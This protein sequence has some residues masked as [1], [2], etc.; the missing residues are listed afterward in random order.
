[1]V[2]DNNPAAPQPPQAAGPGSSGV[3]VTVPPLPAGINTLRVVQQV[4]VGAP[5]PKNVVESN[6]SLFYLQPVIQQPPTPGTPAGGVT[7]VTVQLEPA[8][9]STQRVQLL[10]N[11]LAP[12]AAP[13]P[14][15]HLRRRSVADRREQRDLRYLRHPA[16]RLPRPRAGGRRRER[17]A[18]GPAY[19]HDYSGPVVTL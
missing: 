10:L 2:F 11:E 14:V 8:L 19:P 5:P 7:P 6:V 13:S 1:M 4:A 12:P 17:P 9:E 18:D 16:G 3:S 15:V